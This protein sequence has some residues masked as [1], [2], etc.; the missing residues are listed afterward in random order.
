MEIVIHYYNSFLF[1]HLIYFNRM[2]YY[3]YLSLNDHHVEQD[4]FRN[5]LISLLFIT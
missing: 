4:T 1:I 5:K 2:K 3:L